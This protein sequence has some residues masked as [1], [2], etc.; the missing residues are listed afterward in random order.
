MVPPRRRLGHLRPLLR[1]GLRL[2]GLLF[3]VLDRPFRTGGMTF[4]VPRAGTSREYRGRY[5]LGLYERPERILVRR[6]VP[7]D[8]AV[9]E[10]GAAVGVVSCLLNGR[11]EVPSDH[12]AVEPNPLL[13]VSLRA[14]R[15][16]NGC[17]FQIV[18][19]LV[20][21]GTTVPFNVSMARPLGNR[22][23]REGGETHHVPC[24]A[25]E[26]LQARVA[27]PFDCLVM[28]IEGAEADVVPAA[29]RALP[30][31]RRIVLEQHPAI[32]GA[33]AVERLREELRAHGFACIDRLRDVECWTRG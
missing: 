10:L 11:L 13:L 8:A 7:R 27:R 21:E 5:L 2:S 9:L 12:V 19:G 33:D 16:H 3:D 1:A 25:F 17:G 29:L 28:D 32:I 4:D 15:A 23:G 14:N 30:A 18:H 26:A 20:A 22:L 24:L 31:L 6:H